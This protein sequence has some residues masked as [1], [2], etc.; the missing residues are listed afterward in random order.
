MTASAPEDEALNFAE[1]LMCNPVEAWS[2]LIAA[3]LA[4]C[5]QE[6]MEEA[7]KV[8]E[9]HRTRTAVAW[10]HPHYVGPCGC[11]TAIRNRAGRAPSCAKVRA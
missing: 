7:A 5:R 10:N 9:E 2:D 6:G 4:A 8:C 1:V 11:A 3:R